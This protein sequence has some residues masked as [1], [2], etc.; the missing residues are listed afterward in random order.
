MNTTLKTGFSQISGEPMDGSGKILF[1][2]H[3]GTKAKITIYITAQS[4]QS[5][6][7]Y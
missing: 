6:L 5:F 1:E 4:V 2:N 7:T 3:P